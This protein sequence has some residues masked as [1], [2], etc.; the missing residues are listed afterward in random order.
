MNLYCSQYNLDGAKTICGMLE[1]LMKCCETTLEYKRMLRVCLSGQTVGKEDVTSTF[2]VPGLEFVPQIVAFVNESGIPTKEEMNTMMAPFARMFDKDFLFN[3]L[4]PMKGIWT[5]AEDLLLLEGIEL[6]DRNWDAIQKWF[7]PGKTKNQ[8]AIRFKNRCA[9]RSS[10][11]IIKN[12]ARSAPLTQQEITL[13][14]QG[15]QKHGQNWQNIR[16]EFL[17][18]KTINSLRRAYSD[19][20]K[21][22]TSVVQEPPALPAPEER[23]LPPPPK[24]AN[25]IVPVERPKSPEE[26]GNEE[27]LSSDVEHEEWTDDE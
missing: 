22:V 26:G 27:A 17:P 3:S 19:F 21:N 8:I 11:N 18:S 2:S 12:A 5:E 24:V 13:L 23:I 20:R 1:A 9:S 25:V 4:P 15:V 6:Y 10:D 14:L 7:L 16:T